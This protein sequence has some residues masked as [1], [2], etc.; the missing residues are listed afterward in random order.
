MSPA[1][2]G[3]PP[4]PCFFSFCAPLF[5]LQLTRLPSRRLSRKA[6]LDLVSYF[7]NLDNAAI[8]DA[9]QKEGADDDDDDDDGEDE[10]DGDD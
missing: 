6:T 10:D 8:P 5:C 4:P 2:S 1:Q 9:L 3:P 7:R